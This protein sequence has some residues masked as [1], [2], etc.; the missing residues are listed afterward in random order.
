MFSNYPK[1]PINQ[2][3]ILSHDSQFD[4]LVNLKNDLSKYTVSNGSVQID[5]NTLESDISH[6]DNLIVYKQVPYERDNIHKCQV[7]TI[8]Y[9]FQVD[10]KWL[11]DKCIEEF[12]NKT[13][14]VKPFI[15]QNVN[16]YKSVYGS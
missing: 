11:I 10:V 9:A 8:L 15:F 16:S 4:D 7:E 1:R 13:N 14:N 12:E 3:T 6:T 5:Y 2:N